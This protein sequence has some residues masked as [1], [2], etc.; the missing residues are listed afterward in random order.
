LLK[1]EEKVDKK[2]SFSG[3]VCFTQ[4]LVV[5]TELTAKSSSAS[6]LLHE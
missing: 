6:K 5:S 4:C 2:R 3:A 1:Q